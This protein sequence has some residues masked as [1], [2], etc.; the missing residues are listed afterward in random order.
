MA[1]KLSL[2]AVDMLLRNLT[3]TS[4]ILGGKTVVLGSKFRQVPPVVPRG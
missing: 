4:E 2:E 1:P 3:Q